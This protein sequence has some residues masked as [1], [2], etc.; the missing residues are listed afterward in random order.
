MSL[1]AIK[2]RLQ[3]SNRFGRKDEDTSQ[4]LIRADIVLTIPNVVSRPPMEEMQA[5]L[6]RAVQI[7]LKM[8]EDIQQWDHLI[9]QQRQQQ[10][11][12][13]LPITASLQ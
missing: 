8:S 10:K 9:H 3:V 7:M 13:Q 1:D 12:S 6:T 5:Q 4:P 11:V 2:K